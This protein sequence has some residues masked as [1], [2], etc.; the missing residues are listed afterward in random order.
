[1]HVLTT[2]AKRA[3]PGGTKAL[4]AESLI[5]KHQLQIAHRSSGKSPPLTKLF[6]L[7]LVLELSG[8]VSLQ[9]IRPLPSFV[10]A[11]IAPGDTVKVVT[12]D[13][14]ESTFVVTEITDTAL[15]G[16]NQ[17][18]AFEDIEEL[19]LRS[20]DRPSYPCGGSKP[21]GCSLPKIAYAAAAV[22]TVA[23]SVWHVPNLGLYVL[24]DHFYAACVQHDFCYRHGLETYGLS[25]EACDNDFL[26]DMREICGFDPLCRFVAR[27]FYEAV[28]AKGEK[29][30]RT[31]D[32]SY[33]EY[34]G[35]PVPPENS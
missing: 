33:C 25:R 29:A 8:C 4:I 22:G 28:H 9:T 11:A 18:I 12:H 2:L 3:G 19:Y 1:M 6:L 26:A 35:P 7:L 16:N 5:V 21:L 14:M 23:E 17:N 30:F 24:D 10:A 20:R 27:Q 34:D 31:N 13:S 32:S 15:M